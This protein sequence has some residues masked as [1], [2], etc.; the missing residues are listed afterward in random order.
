MTAAEV[1]GSLIAPRI[2]ES[3]DIARRLLE[4]SYTAVRLMGATDRRQTYAGAVERFNG[5]IAR[6][7][8]EGLHKP[9]RAVLVNVF[10][11]TEILQA[12]G[13]TPLFPEGISVYVAN[14]HCAEPFAD[15]A[16][17]RN[18]PESFCSYHKI[19][20]GMEETG[21]LPSPA[22]IAHTT[23]ACD[24][25]QVS[26]RRLAERYGASRTVIDVPR[27]PSESAVKY[28]EDQLYELTARLEDQ[29]NVRL[30]ID[31]LRAVMQRSA[32]TMQNVNDY[33]DVRGKVS[34]P[35][36]LTGE[37]MHMMSTHLYMGTQAAL[38]FTGATLEYARR[39]P[40]ASASGQPRVFCLH[41]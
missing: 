37:L 31:K 4:V 21:V 9:E 33:M 40:A 1:A 32:Q 18:V 29:L 28:V 10:M 19:M 24:A 11:P 7:I 14:T 35:T 3:P 8:V 16:E 13:L 22:L 30:D 27:T 2:A 15:A 20:V 12:M 26:F 5:K 41:T 38:R 36:S 17:E 34:L 6:T 25:N 39:A 23:L